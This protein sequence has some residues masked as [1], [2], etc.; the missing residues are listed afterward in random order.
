MKSQWLTFSKFYLTELLEQIVKG[1]MKKITKVSMGG[2][3]NTQEPPMFRGRTGKRPLNQS[4]KG[5][6]GKG[7][8]F[9]TGWGSPVEARTDG[10]I[11][12][13][14]NNEDDRNLN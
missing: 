12:F 4:N 6:I 9:I 2:G 13:L 1:R 10:S 14:D 5:C 11:R 8:T 3:Q 7:I